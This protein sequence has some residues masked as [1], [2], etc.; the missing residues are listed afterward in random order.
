MEEIP[1][2]QCGRIRRQPPIQA[3]KNFGMGLGDA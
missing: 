2:E 3:G 1:P